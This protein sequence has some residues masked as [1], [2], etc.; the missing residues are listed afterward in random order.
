MINNKKV[1]ELELNHDFGFTFEDDDEN[2][3]SSL[4]EEVVVLKRKVQHLNGRLEQL[5]DIFMPLLENLSKNPD[6]VMIKWPNRKAVLED[7]IER[8]KALTELIKL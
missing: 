4:Q 3:N 5:R 7:Q 6:K 2:L 8:L 1:T